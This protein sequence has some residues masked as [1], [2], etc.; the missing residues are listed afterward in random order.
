MVVSSFVTK[1]GI[2]RYHHEQGRHAKRL[3]SSLHGQGHDEGLFYTIKTMY[4]FLPYLCRSAVP[5][6][7]Q[8]ELTM[9]LTVPV[10]QEVGFA[11]RGVGQAGKQRD[12]GSNPLLL[13]FLFKSCGLWTLSL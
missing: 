10:E 8:S 5:S 9:A 3:V 11:A 2:T 6:H 13:S 1:R 7:V 12:V 4:P